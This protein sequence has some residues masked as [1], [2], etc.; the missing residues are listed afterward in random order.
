M[1]PTSEV[2]GTVSWAS[3]ERVTRQNS[4]PRVG[5]LEKVT[6]GGAGLLDVAA[7]ASADVEDQGHGDGIVLHG[8]GG[9]LLLHLVVED[10]EVFAVEAGDGPV[11]FI[12]DFDR[13]Q[14]EGGVDAQVD[15]RLIYFGI[16]FGLRRRD[17]L[18]AR[19]EWGPGRER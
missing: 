2:S 14:D 17:G 1:L 8:E 5:G 18:L 10:L 7:H 13:D 16:R 11:E 6:G 19:A 9:D 4:S 15:V 3:L 12:A